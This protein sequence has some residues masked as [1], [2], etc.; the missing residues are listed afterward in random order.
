MTFIDPNT[1]QNPTTGLV[2]PFAWGDDV[3]GS[4]NFLRGPKAGCRV[5]SVTGTAIGGD[6]VLPWATE[7]FDVNACHDN[8]TNNS[9]I[10][11]PTDW[12]GLW[13]V[14]ANIAFDASAGTIE[15]VD[16]VKNAAS[17]IVFAQSRPS[18]VAHTVGVSLDT[19]ITMTAGDYFEAWATG[20]D[21]RSTT[22]TSSFFAFWI[23]SGV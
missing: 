6:T 5:T 9:R 13:Y 11:V 2:A 1:A 21:T 15:L 17:R 8:V 23:A 7:A 14:G 4:F 12:G 20:A 3:D 19:I 16:I 10:T 22:V 18:S